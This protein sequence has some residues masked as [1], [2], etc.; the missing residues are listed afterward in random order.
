M[1]NIA[2]YIKI[3]S[4]SAIPVLLA[5]ILHEVGHGW[6]A[7]R[8]GDPTAKH[9]GRL[10]LNPISHVD[11][12]GTI[13]LPILL[14]I[15][16]A[17]KVVFGYAKPVPINPYNLRD[18]RKDMIWV[19][20]AGPLTNFILAILSAILLRLLSLLR[21]SPFARSLPAASRAEPGPLGPLP[22]GLDVFDEYSDQYCAGII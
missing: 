5:I 19:A 20:G 6:V 4:I 11:I 2:Y 21:S 22:I 18:P 1:E 14:L 8:L 13:I 10:T 17:G 12:F 3:I 15:T 9:A 7:N 16:T